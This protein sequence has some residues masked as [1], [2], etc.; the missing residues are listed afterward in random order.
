MKKVYEIP[1]IEVTLMESTEL[2]QATSMGVFSDDTPIDDP[3]AIR[4]REIL[5]LDED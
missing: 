3:N 4:S 1:E 5:F 2:M